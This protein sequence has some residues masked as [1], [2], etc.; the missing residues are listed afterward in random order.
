MSIICVVS[1]ARTG[2][3]TKDQKDKGQRT[4]DTEGLEQDDGSGR[5]GS[6][7]QDKDNRIMWTVAEDGI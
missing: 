6:G 2:T 7:G 1:S 4:T 5:T 3:G